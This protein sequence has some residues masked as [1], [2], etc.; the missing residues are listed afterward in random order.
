MATAAE[1]LTNWP[2][3]YRPGKKDSRE[4]KDALQEMVVDESDL[5]ELDFSDDWDS[6]VTGCLTEVSGNVIAEPNHECDDVLKVNF[7]EQKLTLPQF[8]GNLHSLE[9]DVK[10]CDVRYVGFVG[11]GGEEENDVY[12]E[13]LIVLSI[14][15]QVDRGIV[16][17]YLRTED[18]KTSLMA[19]N[20]VSK[21]MYEACGK[22]DVRLRKF[23]RLL[24]GRVSVSTCSVA[25]QEAREKTMIENA[26][27]KNKKANGTTLESDAILNNGHAEGELEEEEEKENPDL[28][29]LDSKEM[30]FIIDEESLCLLRHSLSPKP[31]SDFRF[32][33]EEMEKSIDMI[34]VCNATGQLEVQQQQKVFFL[35]S[36]VT[37]GDDKN[38][39]ELSEMLSKSTIKPKQ[40]V[41]FNDLTQFVKFYDPRPVQPKSEPKP[42]PTA[43]SPAAV[44]KQPMGS[45]APRQEPA[46]SV[47]Q[48][49]KLAKGGVPHWLVCLQ[50]G[51]HLQAGDEELQIQWFTIEDELQRNLAQGTIP[52]TEIESAGMNP[53][54]PE[55]LMTAIESI[56]DELY[57]S[58]NQNLPLA[59]SHLK[60]ILKVFGQT[61]LQPVVGLGEVEILKRIFFLSA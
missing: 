19:V 45:P 1:N 47:G 56:K 24:H 55:Q 2:W 42:K 16:N 37:N 25:E 5:A 33:K 46:P 22:N 27:N 39:S 50:T 36:T 34:Y 35:S 3:L 17:I 53:D 8:I 31:V 23:C 15:I 11:G 13:F 40:E 51:S 60:G 10:A 29:Q 21:M 12:N 28:E 43:V 9:R 6:V 38:F 44:P 18:V 59:I 41:V 49:G 52:D 54:N 26:K 48:S 30:F 58:E 14:W 20:A 4:V 32:Y 61:L 57:N 7:K